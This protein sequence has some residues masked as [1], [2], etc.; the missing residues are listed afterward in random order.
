M[1][2]N[3]LKLEESLLKEIY[4]LLAPKQSLAGYVREVLRKEIDSYYRKKSAERYVSFLTQDKEVKTE[5]ELWS[6][7]DLDS[8]PVLR[9]NPV[10]RKKNNIRKR[11]KKN[12]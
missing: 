4:P 3:T 5:E 7:S 8:D 1:R 9:T 10:Q 11:I 12:A 2:A 6:T